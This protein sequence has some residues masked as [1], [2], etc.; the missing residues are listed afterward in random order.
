MIHELVDPR[1]EKSD[2]KLWSGRK[3]VG[4]GYWGESS[5]GVFDLTA[6][7]DWIRLFIDFKTV[8]SVWF[9]G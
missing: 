5:K 7:L 2:L 1:E 6:I 4:F 3:W 9:D 8:P